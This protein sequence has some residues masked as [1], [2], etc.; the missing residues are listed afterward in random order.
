[1]AAVVCIMKEKIGIHQFVA[2]SYKETYTDCSEVILNLFYFIYL[3]GTCQ[4][5]GQV[6]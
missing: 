6:A 4:H 3:T 2:Q 5:E 1:M